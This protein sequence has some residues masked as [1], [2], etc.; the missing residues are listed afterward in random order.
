MALMPY[1]QVRDLRNLIS[2]AGVE[3]RVDD[4]PP[5]ILGDVIGAGSDDIDEHCFSRYRLVLQNGGNGWIRRRCAELS[6][7]YLCRRRAN[8]V[9]S[10]LAAREVEVRKRL[11]DVLAGRY[12]IPNAAETKPAIPVLSQGRVVLTPVGP[13]TVIE[14]FSR[15]TGSPQGYIQHRD[16]VDYF[17]SPALSWWW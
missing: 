13:I 4:Q 3:L 6:V 14:Q 2:V 8:E 15:S 1:C 17:Y 7:C 11:A 9:P 10:S 5:D 12:N 16:P